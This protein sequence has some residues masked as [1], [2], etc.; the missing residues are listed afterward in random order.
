MWVCV[1]IGDLWA[2]ADVQTQKQGRKGLSVPW[3]LNTN[4]IASKRHQ[5]HKNFSNFPPHRNGS[6]KGKRV[7]K[8]MFYYPKGNLV[9]GW[10]GVKIQ[11]P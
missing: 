3:D 7:G 1:Q 4:S 9:G 5:S 2:V 8:S 10:G 6:G 11:S